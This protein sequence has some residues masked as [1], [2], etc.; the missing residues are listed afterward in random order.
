MSWSN[1]KKMKFYNSINFINYKPSEYFKKNILKNWI[2]LDIIKIVS[3]FLQNTWMQ[4]KNKCISNNWKIE[5]LQIYKK[6]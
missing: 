3:W 4:G 6:R 1:K 5:N 2:Q